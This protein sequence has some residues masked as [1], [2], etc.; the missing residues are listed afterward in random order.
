M[1]QKWVSLIVVAPV[2]VI[3]SGAQDSRA[4]LSGFSAGL[5]KSYRWG[6]SGVGGAGMH[7]A[8]N[9]L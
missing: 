8:E 5:H 7:C 9:G 6:A 1:L 2:A 4:G 3:E